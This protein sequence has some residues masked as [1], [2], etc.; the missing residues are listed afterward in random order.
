MFLVSY[1][2]AITQMYLI[3]IRILFEFTTH[4][5]RSYY[6][7]PSFCNGYSLID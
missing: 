5:P 6:R 4:F 3:D 7:L 1:I 2:S